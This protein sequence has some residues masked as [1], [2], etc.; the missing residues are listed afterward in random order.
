MSNADQITAAVAQARG[1][2]PNLPE[3]Y[4]PQA[5]ASGKTLSDVQ[6]DLFAQMTANPRERGKALMRAEVERQGLT[7]GNRPDAT[8][9]APGSPARGVSLMADE[10]ARR[11][12]TPNRR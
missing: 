2:L 1:R 8:A 5:I 7:K 11:G 4:G 9:A 3:D 12:M 10:V 6:A